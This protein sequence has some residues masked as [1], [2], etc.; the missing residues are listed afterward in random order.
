L[1]PQLAQNFAGG[2][3]SCPH[4]GQASGAGAPHSVQNLL[5]A[6]SSAW[7]FRHF[8]PH[9]DLSGVNLAQP[10]AA[11]INDAGSGECLLAAAVPKSAIG[12]YC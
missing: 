9:P 2:G 12:G 4:A 8:M 3:L 5:P 7:H 6:E 1:L 11:V 10:I